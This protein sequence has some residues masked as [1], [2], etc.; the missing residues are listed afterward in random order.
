MAAA[1]SLFITNNGAAVVMFP[2]VMTLARDLGV[3]PLPFVF[4]LM[5]AAGS[6][7]I[8]PVT[9]QTHLMVWGPGGYKFADFAR[10]GAPL[11]LLLALVCT[12]VAPLAFPF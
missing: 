7:Y 11:T 8:S 2:I 6:N 5:V 1:F 10:L 4:T 9:Y 3:S 12:F